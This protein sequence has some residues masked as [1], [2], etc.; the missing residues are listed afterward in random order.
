MKVCKYLHL[1]LGAKKA[2]I[3]N[4]EREALDNKRKIDTM[5]EENLKLKQKL[6]KE[7]EQSRD[8]ALSW[9]TKIENL[10]K[11]LT[12]KESQSLESSI[13]RSS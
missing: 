2:I 7:S 3:G 13:G 8:D 11:Q 1:E 9:K 12:R 5:Q 4:L 6:S 10:E